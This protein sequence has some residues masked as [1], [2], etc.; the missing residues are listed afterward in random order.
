M[1]DTA[2]AARAGVR[3]ETLSR[4]RG[5]ESCD[6]QTLRSLAHAVEAQFGI[7]ELHPPD[8]TDDGHFPAM[9]DRDYEERLVKLSASG[10]FDP[11]RWL[12]LGPRF[13]MAGLAV[14]LASRRDAA[15]GALLQLAERLHP[16]AS[17]V[18]V[19]DRWLARSPLRP[20]RFLPLV[21]EARRAA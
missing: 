19:F 4:L 21:D 2:W 6:F 14:M 9:L 20:A 5:H 8:S 3:K 16:G 17:E 12:D 10:D 11:L 1:T 18:S 7:L 13:F 15:R